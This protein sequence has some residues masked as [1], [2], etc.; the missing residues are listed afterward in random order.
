MQQCHAAVIRFV[1]C[2]NA[3]LSASL[4][5]TQMHRTLQGRLGGRRCLRDGGKH[6]CI[7]WR[8]PTHDG[9][10]SVQ[11]YHNEECVAKTTVNI[12]LEMVV[13]HAQQCSASMKQFL[14]GQA[15]PTLQ[16][17]LSRRCAHNGG[18]HTQPCT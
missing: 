16:G 2:W 6:I 11:P 10:F 1:R 8:R 13:Q 4:P 14:K 7:H 18:R 17:C 12:E 9:H 15:Q 3:I 5:E